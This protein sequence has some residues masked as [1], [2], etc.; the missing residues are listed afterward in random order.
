[1]RDQE[2][3]CIALGVERQVEGGVDIKLS[4]LVN[5]NS[6]KLMLHLLGIES[7]KDLK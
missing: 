4:E 3:R 1:M 2:Q 5:M 6:L 7:W